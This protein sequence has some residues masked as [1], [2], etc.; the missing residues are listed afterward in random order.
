MRSQTLHLL[1]LGTSL[2]M[3]GCTSTHKGQGGDTAGP[4][5][6]GGGE[7]TIVVQ[8]GLVP[9]YT[10]I[11]L[12]VAV[13]VL[14]DAD[15]SS[16]EPTGAYGVS[17]VALYNSPG[18][19]LPTAQAGPDDQCWIDGQPIKGLGKGYAGPHIQ[20]LAGATVLDLSYKGKGGAYMANPDGAK[21]SAIA[22]GGGAISIDGTSTGY[23]VPM[24]M[25][26]E[27]LGS[28]WQGYRDGDLLDL[29]WHPAETEVPGTRTHLLMYLD[30]GTQ[31]D[32]VLADDGG[33]RID[34]SSLTASAVVFTFGRIVAGVVDH[35]TYGRTLV[36]LVQDLFETPK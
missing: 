23:Q 9:T 1:W 33:A 6:T 27:E 10:D 14:W 8:S 7:Q 24:P 3:A 34:L 35:P 4:T 15:P 19:D 2:L 13:Q 18:L 11:D 12:F 17:A 29:Q 32:C 16:L 36:Y 30:D 22:S 5:D 26:A 25:V 28:S 21:G 20:V 31:V